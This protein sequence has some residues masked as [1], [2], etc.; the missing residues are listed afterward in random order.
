[1]NNK[2]NEKKYFFQPVRGGGAIAPIAPPMDPPLK[3]EDIN[4]DD[5]IFSAVPIWFFLH[6]QNHCE[7]SYTVQNPIDSF[8]WNSSYQ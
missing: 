7:T 6:F 5:D 3:Y 1:M 4:F 2:T 8:H